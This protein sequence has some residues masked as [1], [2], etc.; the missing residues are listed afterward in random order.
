MKIYAWT[1]LTILLATGCSTAPRHSVLWHSDWKKNCAGH[2]LEGVM[3]WGYRDDCV[4]VYRF[5]YRKKPPPDSI[6][7]T[8]PESGE[9]SFS[10]RIFGRDK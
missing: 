10:K 7:K 5:H 6:E 1:I 9:G 8:R 3:E 2:N 4:V